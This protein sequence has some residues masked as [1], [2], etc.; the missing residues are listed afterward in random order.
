MGRGY[1]FAGEQRWH[2]ARLEFE[3]AIALEKDSQDTTVVPK[4]GQP[5]GSVWSTFR[6]EAT[7]QQGWCM[8]KEAMLAEGIA[9]LQGVAEV[10]DLDVARKIDSARV[11]WRIGVAEWEMGGKLGLRGC[12]VES[13]H[14][15]SPQV[16]IETRPSK[17]SSNRCDTSMPLLPPLLQW[18]FGTSIRQIHQMKIGLRNASRKLS[19]SML[20]KPKLREGLQ[21]A[22]PGRKN[23]LS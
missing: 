4:E 21:R 3:K 17:H 6:L 14:V 16:K 20:P 12:C 19:S 7:E 9:V 8:T 15:L 1:V 11:R 23:G 18:V 13:A 2:E 5:A 10:F 22:M